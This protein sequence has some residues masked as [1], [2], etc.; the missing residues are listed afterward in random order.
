MVR[1][2]RQ[3]PDRDH[4]PILVRR[5]ARRRGRGGTTRL[6]QLG[7]RILLYLAAAAALVWLTCAALRPY[8]LDRDEVA[9]IRR[10]SAEVAAAEAENE[11]L[12]R[13]IGVLRTPKGVEVEARRHGWVQPGEVLIQTSET[14]PPPPA[15]VPE[16]AATPPL[17]AVRPQPE[18]GILG[19]AIERLSRAVRRRRPAEP[20]TKEK[21]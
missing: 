20:K 16:T 18:T 15:K 11:A 6:W 13:R 14:P 17:G 19:Q 1:P 10:L 2:V 4:E 21:P 7:K 8:L 3:P 12:R 5:G 9:E